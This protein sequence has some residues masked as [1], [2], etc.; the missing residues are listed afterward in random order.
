MT[1]RLKG[2][3]MEFVDRDSELAFHELVRAFAADG[4]LALVGAGSSARVATRVGQGS[5]AG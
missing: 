5:L 1:R 2:R 4:V 3:R